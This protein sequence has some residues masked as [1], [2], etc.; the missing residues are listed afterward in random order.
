MQRSMSN[1]LGRL[2]NIGNDKDKDPRDEDPQKGTQNIV[3]NAESYV[4]L[5]IYK[6]ALA[7]A[8]DIIST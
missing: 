2:I 8:R 3:E 5:N 4:V 1:L 6:H 7:A